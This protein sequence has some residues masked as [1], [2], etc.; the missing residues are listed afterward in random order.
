[1][2]LETAKHQQNLLKIYQEYADKRKDLI[3]SNDKLALSLNQDSRKKEIDIAAKSFEEEKVELQRKIR[4]EIDFRA[5]YQKELELKTKAYDK[6]IVEINTKWDLIDLQNQANHY[7][8]KLE[9][10]QNFSEEQQ[11]L[12]I[13]Q[14][15]ILR[16]IEIK[17]AEKTGADVSLIKKKYAKK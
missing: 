9:S 11:D 12:L 4:D 14:N 1:M 3:L 2:T 8:L 7:A 6:S 13:K 5:E 15:E 10:T 16:D 17:E